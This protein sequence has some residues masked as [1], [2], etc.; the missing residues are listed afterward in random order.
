[1]LLV[2]GRLEGESRSK[3]ASEG[4]RE[5]GGYTVSRGEPAG[6]ESHGRQHSR[7]HAD[8]NQGPLGRDQFPRGVGADFV[9]GTVV[10][11]LRQLQLPAEGRLYQPK[12][13]AVAGSSTV[14]AIVAGGS[15]EELRQAEA[16][17]FELRSSQA[18][19]RTKRSQV[20]HSRSVFFFS[21]S[22]SLSL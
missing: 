20:T 21:L 2:G 8:R 17:G 5:E 15:Q 16:G 4:E 13:Q 18:L 10:R 7:E 11:S 6:R 12:G 22:L 9:Q 14:W 1:M 3:D 19:P